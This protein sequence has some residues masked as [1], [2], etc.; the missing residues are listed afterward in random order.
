MTSRTGG[1]SVKDRS[2]VARALT[3]VCK[4]G[5]PLTTTMAEP[6]PNG[7]AVYCASSTGTQSA[8]AHAALCTPRRSPAACTA[9]I[10]GSR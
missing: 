2:R 6:A 4:D 9:L 10:P 5:N 7:I 3:Q 8:Y 1:A